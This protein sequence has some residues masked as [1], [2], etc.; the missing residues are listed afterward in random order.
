MRRPRLS[1]DHLEEQ[2]ETFARMLQD[3]L[4]FLEVYYS[5]HLVPL[6]HGLMNAVPRCLTFLLTATL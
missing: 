1:I 4:L 3:M 6:L 5:H 2:Q